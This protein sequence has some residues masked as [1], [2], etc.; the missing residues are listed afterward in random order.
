[1]ATKVSITSMIVDA[2][3]TLYD[4]HDLERHEDM[5]VQ[6]FWSGLVYA[7]NKPA[8]VETI[9]HIASYYATHK[10]IPFKLLRGAFNIFVVDADRTIC[11]ADNSGMRTLFYSETAVSESF[12]ALVRHLSLTHN[13]V[14]EFDLESASEAFAIGR[15]LD[16]RTLIKSVN[17]L[18]RFYFIEI[19]EGNATVRQKPIEDVNVKDANFDPSRLFD[20]LGAAVQQDSPVSC[21]LTGGYDSRMVYAYALNRMNVIPTLSGDITKSREV[22]VAEQTAIA[23]GQELTFMQIDQP[24]LDDIT[25]RSLFFQQDGAT[26]FLS[27]ANLRINGYYKRLAESTISLHLTGDGGILHK[28]WY[29]I[30][31][32]PFY[33]R[34]TTNLRRFYSLRL[35][36]RLESSQVGSLIADE[37]R[38]LEPRAISVLRKYSR[39]TNTQTYDSLYYNV[40]GQRSVYYNNTVHNV[41]IYAPLLEKDMVAYSY[42]LP[43]FLRFFNNSMR[44][45]TTNQNRSAARVPTVYGTTSSS[46]PHLVLRDL[47]FQGY[48]YFIRA[49]R[50]LG[51]RFLGRTLFTEKVSS[52]SAT[53]EIR[54]LTMAQNAVKYA[55]DSEFLSST[56]SLAEISRKHLDFAVQMYLT[57]EIAGLLPAGAA[58]DE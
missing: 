53:E 56:T 10:Q 15:I 39:E 1:M 51:R 27:D 3:L 19:S 38:T 24:E 23:A 14:L 12:L 32:F 42:N 18:E 13:H 2:S 45:L 57:A 29:W 49:L 34:K 21:A 6:Y 50:L 47:F 16:F 7:E 35:K 52:W 46:E 55:V 33:K 43:R 31:D 5:G 22:Q 28:D 58:V 30:Q 48:G 17:M 26:E 9:K 41:T 4:E 8:G 40:N 44:K 54:N 37:L 36:H 25:I 20:E 11:F